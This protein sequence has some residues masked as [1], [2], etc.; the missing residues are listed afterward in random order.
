MASGTACAAVPSPTEARNPRLEG[1]AGV[2]SSD[3][4]TGDEQNLL[5]DASVEF[6]CLTFHGGPQYSPT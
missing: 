6:F 3:I 1:P 2:C 4:I 5:Q